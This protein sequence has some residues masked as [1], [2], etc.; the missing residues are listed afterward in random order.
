MVSVMHRYQSAS[1]VYTTH[2]ISSSACHLMR[3]WGIESKEKVP[4]NPPA[5][6]PSA[7]SLTRGGGVG[8]W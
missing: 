5:F 8:E 7:R 2:H 3:L 4:S 6:A 1:A